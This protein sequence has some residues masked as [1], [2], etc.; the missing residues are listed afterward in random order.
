MRISYQWL[1]S[2][3]PEQPDPHRLAAILTGTGLE[4]ESLE[5]MEP[6]KGNLEGLVIGEVLEVSPHP[7]ADRLKLTLVNTGKGRPLQIVCGAPNVAVG[8]KVVVAEPGTTIYPLNGKPV[9]MKAAKIRGAES[10][11]MICAED[12]IGLGSG[13][14][15]ILVLHDGATPGMMARDYFQLPEDW[16][17]EIG[18]TPNRMDAMSHIGVARDVCAFLS[19]LEGRPVE[20]KIPSVEEFRPVT[21]QR[22][23]AV[24]VE[25]PAACPRYSGLVI[26]GVKTGESP[27]WLQQRLKAIGLRPLNNIVD[28]TNFVLHECGQPLHAFDAGRIRGGRVIVKNLPKDTPFVTLDE[29]ER[30]LD[31]ED[32]MI[33]DDEGPMCI[34]GVFGGLDSG[35]TA[36]TT[37]LFLESAFFSGPGIR[38][39]SFRH[40]LRTDAAIRF[41]KGVDISG[42]LFAL[43]RAALLIT[44]IAGGTVAS[45]ITDIYPDP[46]KEATIRL[47]A[48]YLH[49]LSGKQYAPAKVKNILAR[50]GFK[51]KEENNEGITVSPPFSK[52][53]ITLPA[54][55]VEEVMRIDGYDNVEIPAR[56]SISPSIPQ[57]DKEILREKVSHYLSGNGFCEIFTNSITNSRYFPA[58]NED[59]LV[60]MINNLSADLDILRPSMLETG[61]ETL[62]YNLNRQQDDL[63]FYEFGKTYTR[64]NGHYLE[65]EHLCLYLTGN[66]RPESWTG[67]NLKIDP[68]FIKGFLLNIAALTGLAGSTAPGSGRADLG[69]QQALLVHNKPVAVFGEVDAQRLRSF[70]IRQPVWYADIDWEEILQLSRKADIRFQKIP[71]FPS[72]RRDLALILDKNISFAGVEKAARSLQSPLLQEINLFDVF[73]SEKLGAG[74]KSYAVSFV[75]RDPGKT[76]TDTEVDESVQSLVSVF[77]TALGAE[78][79]K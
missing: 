63:L 21:G 7:N 41:E 12:E 4:V 18:L 73:E 6:V 56:V 16:I 35:V 3:L 47:S 5:K 46:R 65:K 14:D 60:R 69:L 32:L 71:K 67:K 59:R 11:G 25:N 58:G 13:H 17:Y 74:K 27:A 34:A 48:D 50:L 49:K 61:L 28:I 53:D 70:D 44:G 29:K 30:K 20:V 24:S 23:I 76:L 37:N 45:E 75:F 52:P 8:Q 68:Y 64:E 36:A 38:A 77:E 51:I 79:R 72:V 55:V 33:C 19:N 15:G 78:I 31:P 10:D 40:G 9:T 57:E 22:P 1:C 62:A 39:S 54:D 26:T 66:K 42:T 2:Y 43:K